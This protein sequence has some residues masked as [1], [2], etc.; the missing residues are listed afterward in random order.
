M[1]ARPAN[2]QDAGGFF[3]AAVECGLVVGEQDLTIVLTSMWH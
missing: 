3:R 2:G 1:E